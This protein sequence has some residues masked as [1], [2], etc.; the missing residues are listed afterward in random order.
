MSSNIRLEKVCQHCGEK[1]IAKTTVT[2]YCGDDCAK[3]A[4]KKR[5][6]EEKINEVKEVDQ[7]LI[8]YRVNDLREK[9]FLSIKETCQLLGASR[10][11]VYRQIKSGFLPAI[12]F[13]RRTIIMKSE[14]HNLFY[15]E[16]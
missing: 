15:H 6:R 3:R 10:M 12:K 9:E 7:Q 8:E 5:K 13:G 14:I 4:Y 1:F 2:K 16:S 11:T